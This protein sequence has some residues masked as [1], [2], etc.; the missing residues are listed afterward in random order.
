MSLGAG[1][2]TVID[3][4]SPAIP[5]RGKF[6]WDSHGEESPALHRRGNERLD[7]SLSSGSNSSRSPSSSP[8][9]ASPS[10]SKSFAGYGYSSNSPS[11]IRQKTPPTL[12]TTYEHPLPTRSLIHALTLPAN[13]QASKLSDFAGPHSQDEEE[14]EEEG[15]DGE[16]EISSFALALLKS[17]QKLAKSPSHNPAA[18][19]SPAVTSSGK[20][21]PFRARSNTLPSKDDAKTNASE[22]SLNEQ[23]SLS[24]LQKELLR[25]NEERNKRMSLHQEKVTGVSKKEPGKRATLTNVLSEKFDD[26]NL[27]MKSPDAFSDNSSDFDDSPNVVTK[28]PMLKAFSVSE[29]MTRSP[30]KSRAPPPTVKPKPT[31]KKT[32]VSIS[33]ISEIPNG[34]LSDDTLP[35]TE[36]DMNGSGRKSSNPVFDVKLHSVQKESVKETIVSSNTSTLSDVS[37]TR[38]IPPVVAPKKSKKKTMSSEGDKSGNLPP[39]DDFLLPPPLAES[40]E[41]KRLSF[42]NLDPPDDFNFKPQTTVKLSRLPPPVSPPPPQESI[43]E[44]SECTEPPSLPSSP[45]PPP[46]MS[47]PPP[48]EDDS[49]TPEVFIFEDHIGDPAVVSS[50]IPVPGSMSNLGDPNSQSINLPSPIPSPV[51]KR[52]SNF[53]SSPLPPPAFGSHDSSTEQDGFWISDENNSVEPQPTLPPFSPSGD[54]LEVSEA[55]PPLPS[56]PPPPLPTEPPP[57]LDSD[58]STENVISPAADVCQNGNV[59]SSDVPSSSGTSPVSYNV[60]M[61]PAKDVE[62]IKVKEEDEPP[63]KIAVETSTEPTKGFLVPAIEEV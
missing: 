16:E 56:E 45:P 53:S 22:S 52:F 21:S 44:V 34:V 28:M 46:P 25:A 32:E 61:A 3:D 20:N 18:Q 29:D 26:M 54:M 10:R 58:T 48:K 62:V 42:V 31:K 50:P 5:R 9:K 40:E 39:P 57:A 11:R 12:P 41:E 1:R 60:S 27:R 19:K 59:S 51:S 43:E 8:S 30:G 47:D 6:E 4:D 63:V 55:P 13:I 14:E 49:I 17:R 37:G 2:E 35:K 36:D 23:D 7:H 38:K 24:S 33:S 15:K